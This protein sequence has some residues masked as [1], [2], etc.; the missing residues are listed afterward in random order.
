MFRSLL[1]ATL[2][3]SAALTADPALAAPLT[4]L[5]SP[6]VEVPTSDVDSQRA[7]DLRN[8]NAS[9]LLPRAECP[10]P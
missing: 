5:K 3:L 9:N 7:L 10:V 1:S 2:L 4:E 8:S 6:N